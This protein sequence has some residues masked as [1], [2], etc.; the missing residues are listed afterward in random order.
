M[1]KQ[2]GEYWFPEIETEI[3]RYGKRYQREKY[4]AALEHVRHRDTAID[5]GGHCG[6]WTLNMQ[7]HF[8]YVKGF[9]PLPI[10]A[11]CYWQNTGQLPDMFAL[12]NK[13]GVATMNYNDS[14][15][16]GN[17]GFGMPGRP[18][19]V[20]CRPLDD[21]VAYFTDTEVGLIK[22]DVEGHEA[23]VLEGGQN[24]IELH[25]PVLIVEQKKNTDALDVLRQ[26]E[27][28]VVKEM[29]RDYIAVP[30]EWLN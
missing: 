7:H 20:I 26:L 29:A 5:I 3:S 6:M 22:I 24:L 1:L 28:T 4:T 10:H 16:T 11:F 14:G 9:E 15:N 27:Y 23:A 12:S 13:V 30:N 19:D 21:Y 18:V 8:D 17:S 25:Q 2:V